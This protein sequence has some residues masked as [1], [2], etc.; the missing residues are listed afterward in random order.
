MRDRSALETESNTPTA[1]FSHWFSARTIPCP[2]TLKLRWFF[3]NAVQSVSETRYSAV[4]CRILATSGD[5]AALLYF[6]GGMSC[7]FS[8]RDF[9]GH[10][11]GRSFPRR[12]YTVTPPGFFER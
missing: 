10:V 12:H 7:G 4:F 9:S 3:F 11:Q 2:I 5:A 1:R 8:C 6:V